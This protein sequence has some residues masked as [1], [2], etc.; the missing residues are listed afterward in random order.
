MQLKNHII[1]FLFFVF[2][3]CKLEAQSDT[4][5]HKHINHLIGIDL[6]YSRYF[7]IVDF[8]GETNINYVFN[9]RFF[10]MKAQL[11]VAPATYFGN[12]IKV[13]G[14][15]GFTTLIKKPVSWHILTGF[16]STFT[17]ESKNED[18]SFGTGPFILETGIYFNL[19]KKRKAIFGLNAT[20]FPMV[21][22]AGKQ[23]SNAY[24]F[25]INLNFNYK[26]NR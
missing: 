16:G 14:K 8:K 9:S 13:F 21:Y 11:G 19:L 25:N 3:S 23:H 15:L 7:N 18:V 12:I 24:T 6:G 4:S 2:V 17:P 22:Y 5:K 26:L 1:I 10:C 20:F